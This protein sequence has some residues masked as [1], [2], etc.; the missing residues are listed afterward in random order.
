MACA[1]TAL[2]MNL[3]SLVGPGT[4]SV[5]AVD[6]RR[7]DVELRFAV[8]GKMVRRSAG[9]YSLGS[10]PGRRFSSHGRDGRCRVFAV[11]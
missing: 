11:A 5:S 3:V 8:V 7:S 10:M 4:L 9:I 1:C 2:P 6:R